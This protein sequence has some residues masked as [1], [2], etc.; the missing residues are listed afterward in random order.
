MSFEF[1]GRNTGQ[2][3]NRI[4]GP[5]TGGAWASYYASLGAFLSAAQADQPWRWIGEPPSSPY[6]GHWTIFWNNPAGPTT[7]ADFA[8][9]AALVQYNFAVDTILALPSGG[10]VVVGQGGTLVMGA[11]VTGV[12]PGQRQAPPTLQ[13]EVAALDL[14]PSTNVTLADRMA[15]LPGQARP[16][17]GVPVPLAKQLRRL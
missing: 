12:T 16:F 5:V 13:N 7:A 15:S 4:T 14:R 17:A 6:Q 8:V 10:N 3:G 11:P 1:T 2:Q 9:V